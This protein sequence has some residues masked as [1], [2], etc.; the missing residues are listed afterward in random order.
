MKRILT[1]AAAAAL[2]VAAPSHAQTQT[3]TQ[4][5]T[6][7]RI[8]VRGQAPAQPGT[9]LPGQTRGQTLGRAGGAPAAVSDALF[10]A[11]AADG[12]L[13]ELTLSQLGV[14]KATD[15]ELKQFSQRMIEEHTRMNAELMNLAAQKGIAL[16][17]TTDYRSQFCA[18]SLAGL[19]GE[20]FDKCYAKAQLLVHMDAVAVFEAEAQRGLDRDVKAWA[21]QTLPRIKEHLKMIKPIAKRYM[22]EEES[23]NRTTSL[24][25]ER[26]AR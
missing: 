19:S 24:G 18:Q 25:T 5:P 7:E 4:R 22:K 6:R 20:E 12:G 21:A 11:A 15:P 17:R 26:P 9:A 1:I 8:G 14:Q 2:L 23:E 13:T 3:R 16:P 10:A